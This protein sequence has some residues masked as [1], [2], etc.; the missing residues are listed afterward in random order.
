M[1]QTTPEDERALAAPNEQRGQ[2][3]KI[4]IAA[5]S[6]LSTA[7]N[8]V[9]INLAHVVIQN[10]YCHGD[11]CKAAVTTAGT[12]CLV[13]AIIGQLTFG[14]LGDC[15]GRGCALQLTMILSI[16]G[17]LAS[18]FAVP[19]TSDPSSIFTFISITRLILG[20]GVGGVYPLA[21]TIAAESSQGEN[22]GRNASLV[23]SMQGVGTIL[24]P[25]VGMVLLN[26]FGRY[27]DRHCGTSG[28]PECGIAWRCIL[29][30][31]ALPG[32][33][34]M[35]FQIAENRKSIQ[36]ASDARRRS[37]PTA[38]L[39]LLQALRTPAYWK[40]IIGCAGGW[41]LFDITFYG[42]TLFAPTVLQAVFGKTNK[43]GLTPTIGDDLQHNLCLQLLILALIGLPGYYISVCFMDKIGRKNIQV[44]GF[45]A[46][47]VLYAALAIF[48]DDLKPYPGP[49]LIIYG[50]TYFFSN[51]GPNSTTFI[52]P[53]E[54]FPYEV[55]TSL[56]GFCAAM[57][58]VG[59]TVGSAAF[60][61]IV[62]ASG[63]QTVF[64]L[65]TLCAAL[66]VLVTTVCIDDR[67]GRGMKGTSFVRQG[68]GDST[69]GISVNEQNAASNDA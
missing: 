46:M 27:Q 42:N 41:F 23:F 59:A 10:H 44:Q 36:A 55:R 38:N 4:I 2:T 43:H 53:S 39:S 15:L 3:K 40:S 7:Y 47:A 50:M 37:S 6:N 60:K 24:V 20:I 51:F 49:L 31:G 13:G 56:N 32:I 29:G 25:V 64:W 48:L 34:L 28:F 16:M 67:R 45:V 17:A 12:A 61:P 62:N 68:S 65:C 66:G 18:A 9:N 11:H 33:I 30:F 63:P 26:V 5:F 22:R 21:A 54:S 8:L 52:L 1:A 69:N 14:Y 19:I 57:G 35:P 58:K